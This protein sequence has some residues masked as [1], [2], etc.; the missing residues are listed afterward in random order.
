MLTATLDVIYWKLGWLC[1]GISMDFPG[2]VSSLACY[3]NKNKRKE[4]SIKKFCK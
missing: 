2:N 4:M 1:K 3:I